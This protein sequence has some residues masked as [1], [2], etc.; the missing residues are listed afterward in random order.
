MKNEVNSMDNSNSFDRDKEIIKIKKRRI[1]K[2]NLHLFVLTIPGLIF[3]LVFNYLPMSGIVIA[4]KRYVPRLGIWGSEWVGFDNF[5]FFFESPDLLRLVRN[6]A[7]YGS[8]F[9]VVDMIGGILLA[10]LLYHLTNKFALKAYKSIIMLPRFLSVIV[11]SYITYALLSP[12]YGIVNQVITALG[13]EA[14]SWYAEPKYWPVIL[15]IVHIWMTIGG[16]CLLYYATLVGIDKNLFEAASID[17]A[18]VLQKCRHV[19][20]PSLKP[21]I[22]MN[23][24]FGV[25]GIVSVDMGLFDAVPRAQGL[26]FPTTD[27][28][29][30]YVYRGLLNGDIE[31]PAAVG[32]A[33]S[34]IILAL[35]LIVNAIIRKVSPENS[36]F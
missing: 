18:T 21:V 36:M 23:L 8:A 34:V 3:L 32:L 12:S 24:T 14:I 16:G 9:L 10:L 27:V 26:L 29:N 5:K 11:V 28:I 20:L 17:G 33:Q 25:G 6:T 35:I 13:G 19:A 31:R 7:L 15:T 30:T 4:F 2:E 22:C 1:F